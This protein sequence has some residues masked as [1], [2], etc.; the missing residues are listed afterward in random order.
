MCWVTVDRGLEISRAFL[1]RD[2]PRWADLRDEIRADLLE[3]GWKDDPGA[4]TAAYDGADLDAAALTVGLTGLLEPGDERFD[5]TVR[6]VEAELRSGPTVYRY[7]CDDGLPGFE[8]GFHLCAGWLVEA[9]LRTGRR[10]DAEE[11]FDAYTA[12][13]GPTGLLSEQFG[14]QSGRSLGNHPQ[15]YSHLMLIENALSLSRDEG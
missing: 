15:A 1:D 13:A 2:Q 6:A 7:R 8:G 5:R 11:L 4:F 3:H 9:Y 10:R 14:P 12:L